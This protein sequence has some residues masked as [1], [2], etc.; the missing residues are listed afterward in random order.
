VTVLVFGLLGIVTGRG[1]A[2]W[3]LIAPVAMV[4]LQPG[5]RLADVRV[6]GIRTPRA[7]TAREASVS[8]ERRSPLNG[9]VIAVLALAGL[10]MLPLLRDVGPAGVPNA[11]LTSAPQGIAAKLRALV[12]AGTI[13]RGAHVWKS[14]ALGILA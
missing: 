13:Q 7:R 8:E 9:L 10:A 14:A 4:K 3:A 6:P 12:S 5:L 1:L 11:T 2:W